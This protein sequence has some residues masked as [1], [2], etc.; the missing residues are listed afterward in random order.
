M[1]IVHKFASALNPA[2]CAIVDT[3]YLIFMVERNSI[4]NN[5][6]VVSKRFFSV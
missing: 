3:Y 4:L 2:F 6:F 5:V 1:L